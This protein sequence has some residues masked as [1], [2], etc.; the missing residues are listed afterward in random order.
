MKTF[1][2]YFK[3]S[4]AIKASNKKDAVRKF[5]QIEFPPCV[6]FED[7]DPDDCEEEME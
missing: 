3:A 4:V 1:R 6:D 7:L 5:H 2:L